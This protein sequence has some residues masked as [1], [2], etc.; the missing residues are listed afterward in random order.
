MSVVS[1]RLEQNP[2]ITASQMSVTYRKSKCEQ[3]N[4]QV[5]SRGLSVGCQG[6]TFLRVVGLGSRKSCGV[7]PEA[8]LSLSIKR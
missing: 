1:R 2:A 7:L 8:K 3:G 5:L 6:K 4:L